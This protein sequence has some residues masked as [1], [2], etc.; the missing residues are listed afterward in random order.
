MNSG[1]SA[2]RTFLPW[3]HSLPIQRPPRLIFRHPRLKEILLLLEINK[4]RHPRKRIGRTGIQYIQPDLLRP[5]IGHKPQVLLEHRR[6]QPQ[7]AA[8]HGVFGVGVFQFDAL[9]ED[10]V[11]F[12]LEFIGPELRVF[13]LDG[14]DQIN[15]EIAVHR[16]VAQDVLI[17]LGG[18]GHFVLAAERE[19]L[20]EAD[21][22]EQAFHDATEDD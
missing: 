20:H 11:D 18:T 1:G 22:E 14:V 5:T 2:P 21:I 7:H 4:L 3:E 16:F 12:F 6:I 10:G 13:Q 9:P 17:L 19:D 8:R 15:T